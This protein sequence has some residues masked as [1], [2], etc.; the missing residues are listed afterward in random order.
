MG[1]N[2]TFKTVIY[3]KYLKN[4][5]GNIDHKKLDFNLLIKEESLKSSTG[6]K[7]EVDHF[8]IERI[9]PKSNS[10]GSSKKEHFNRGE[11]SKDFS[12]FEK[13][14]KIHINIRTKK[15]NFL[16]F[17][18]DNF[19]EL[20]QRAQSTPANTHMYDLDKNEGLQLKDENNNILTI[21][22]HNQKLRE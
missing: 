18:I 1:S 13:G 21:G 16:L 19:A 7:I 9:N 4:D 8:I 11:L 17:K 6:S 5:S 22:I 3:S 20:V 12:A 10:Q 2:E 15:G 14:E